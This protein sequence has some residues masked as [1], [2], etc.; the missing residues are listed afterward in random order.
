MRILLDREEIIQIIKQFI[1]KEYGDVLD[2]TSTDEV[3]LENETL[4]F[5][6]NEELL[7]KAKKKEREIVKPT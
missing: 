5:L 4:I 1:A 2:V 7:V 3:V 6:S